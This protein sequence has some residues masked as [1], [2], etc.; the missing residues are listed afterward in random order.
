MVVK[1]LCLDAQIE[2]MNKA[3]H[4]DRV[5]E[6]RWEKIVRVLLIAT[7]ISIGILVVQFHQHY[8][9]VQRPP[10]TTDN[11]SATTDNPAARSSRI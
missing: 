2:K 1:L 3:L 8:R 6:K 4:A 11:P 9:I 7:S 5:W 10:A